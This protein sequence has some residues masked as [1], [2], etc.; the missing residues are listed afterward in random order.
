[1]R[2]TLVNGRGINDAD[3]ATQKG[4][5]RCPY[6]AAWCRMVQSNER[7][8]E[9]WLL[10]SIFRKWMASQSW[11]GRDLDRHLLGDG[12]FFSE[13]TCCFLPR[14]L[15][16]IVRYMRRGPSVDKPQKDRLKSKPYRTTVGGKH[17]GYFRSEK[18]AEDAWY[19]YRLNQLRPWVPSFEGTKVGD[20]LVRLGNETIQRLST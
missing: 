6:F 7:V 5:K 12:H 3:Y 10:F 9:E 15:S 17:L 18:E 16:N 13:E 4:G 20:A 14:Q 8:H 1:M 2:V 11:K 19:I